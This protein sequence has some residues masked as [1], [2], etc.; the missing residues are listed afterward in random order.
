MR[1]SWDKNIVEFE[2]QDSGETAAMET[3]WRRLVSC[4]G[5]SGKLAPIGEFTPGKK[6]VA[7]FV[8]EGQ[9]EAAK[10][11]PPVQEKVEVEGVY[12]C[13]ICNRYIDLTSG[14]SVPVCCGQPME[15]MD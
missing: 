6:G 3:V 4:T 13:S 8:I 5:E 2:P 11:V 15:R 7:T 14:D 9:G 12:I 1:I 10:D